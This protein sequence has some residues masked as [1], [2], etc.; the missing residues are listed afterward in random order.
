M[1]LMG[2]VLLRES[3]H[4]TSDYLSEMSS[5]ILDSQG[6]V[7]K[8]IGDAVMAF[9]NAPI[10]IQGHA[11]IACG[12]ALRSQQRLR[13]LR[14]GASINYLHRLIIASTLLVWKA[15]GFPEIHTRMGLNTGS[16]LVGNFGSQNRINYTCLGDT[17]NLA[18]RLEVP[19][20]HFY[21]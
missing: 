5:I 14:T 13:D 18:S 3:T 19:S 10:P 2:F 1:E 16:A 20:R 4:L 7:D 15:K 21:F 12:V 17:V 8:F 6:V 11:M 9:W